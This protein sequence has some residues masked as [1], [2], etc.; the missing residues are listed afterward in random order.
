MYTYCSKEQW[1]ENEINQR[2]KNE[3]KDKEGIRSQTKRHR[4]RDTETQRHR[5]TETQREARQRQR[6]TERKMSPFVHLWLTEWI[7]RKWNDN[8]IKQRPRNE[9]KC[10]KGRK[11]EAQ[12]HRSIETQRHRDTDTDTETQ[13]ETQHK[14]QRLPTSDWQNESTENETRMRSNKDRGMKISAKREENRRHSATD[15]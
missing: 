9:N 11:S 1:I 8:E 5:D 15:L 14:R 3:Y 13:T 6:H 12:C 7:N 2:P 10:K 4:H